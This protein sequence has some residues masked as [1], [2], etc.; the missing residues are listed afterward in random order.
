[1]VWPLGKKKI[2]VYAFLADNLGDDLLIRMLCNRYPRVDFKAWLNAGQQTNIADVPNLQIISAQDVKPR[3]SLGS[4]VQKRLVRRNLP[5][6]DPWFYT[7]SA[8]D[9]VV[10]IGGSI[11]VQHQQDWQ[12]FYGADANLVK[13]AR[14]LFVVD[15]NFGPYVDPAYYQSYRQLFREYEDICFRDQASRDAFADHQNVRCAPDV[16]F[17]LKLPPAKAPTGRKVA[18]VSPL[19]LEWRQSLFPLAQYEE[20]YQNFMVGICRQLVEDGY[21]VRFISFCEQQGDVA[22]SRQIMERLRGEGVAQ[23]RLQL[24]AYDGTNQAACL[25]EFV[26]AT[27]VAATRFHAVVLGW[28]AGKPT[29]P[30]VYAKKTQLLLDENDQDFFVRFED[31]STAD[32]ADCARQLENAPVVDVSE[33]VA[34]ADAQFWALD[35]LLGR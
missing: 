4:K 10:H 3:K 27:V 29:L 11:F 32:A 23:E 2:L 15:A 19:Q 1:M 25:Q 12:P 14:K 22:A 35:E 30:L 24:V 26:D 16:V 17:S 28:L 31:L 6:E 33:L 7:L 8:C 21:D 9:A 5:P 20:N 13:A 18:L 34:R